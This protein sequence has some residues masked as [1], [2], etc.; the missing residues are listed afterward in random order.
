M[1]HAPIAADVDEAPDI[2]VYLASKIALDTLLAVD[3]VP[4]TGKLGLAKVFYPWVTFD[5]GFLDHIFGLR[6]PDPKYVG[7]GYLNPLVVRYVD[8]GNDCHALPLRQ[9]GVSP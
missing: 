7:N 4:D 1:P 9:K 2:H 5:T 6:G 8:S 3:D